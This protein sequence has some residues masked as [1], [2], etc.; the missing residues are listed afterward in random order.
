MYGTLLGVV[1]NAS[2]L[3]NRVHG[4]VDLLLPPPGWDALLGPSPAALALRAELF[5]RGVTV[6]SG[7]REAG[8]CANANFRMPPGGGGGAWGRPRR[9]PRGGEGARLDEALI[10]EEPPDYTQSYRHLELSR[11][12]P[13]EGGAPAY[14]VHPWHTRRYAAGALFPLKTVEIEGVPV[15][16]PAHALAITER[17]YGADWRTPDSSPRV[18]GAIEHVAAEDVAG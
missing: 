1:R 2:L 18:H 11:L 8:G 5:S 9:R 3:P 16:V 6:F 12:V 13:L 15:K 14:T 4:D 7:A 10:A 17:E